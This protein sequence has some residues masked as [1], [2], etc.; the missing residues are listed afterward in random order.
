MTELLYNQLFVRI[1][2]GD[3]MKKPAVFDF[4]ATI[5]TKN[6]RAWGNLDIEQKGK[7]NIAKNEEIYEIRLYP[8]R[9]EEGQVKFLS[10][11]DKKTKEVTFIMVVGD[12][13]TKEQ[14]GPIEKYKNFINKFEND[15]NHIVDIQQKKVMKGEE[16]I[17]ELKEEK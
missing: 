4:P 14:K 16:I 2:T 7:L 8:C 6:L 9:F 12:I 13:I 15:F 11:I 10:K 5:E 17:K 1:F 3:K